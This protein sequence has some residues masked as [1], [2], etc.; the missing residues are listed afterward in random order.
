MK[1]NNILLS[2]PMLKL[3]ALILGFCVWFVISQDHIVTI[4][5]QVPLS[6]YNQPKNSQ[7]Y[8][9]ESI[10]VTS[11]GPKNHLNQ[12]FHSDY[13]LHINL[14]SYHQG[15]H[16]IELTQDDLFL[17]QTIKLLQLKPSMVQI[18]IAQ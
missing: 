12:T 4:T 10:S 5:R 13:A 6:F 18:K 17:P 2:K 1:T 8:A 7:L 16:E 3:N 11:F 9:P 14:K 15:N